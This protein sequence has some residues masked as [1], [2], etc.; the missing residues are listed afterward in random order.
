[1]TS[2]CRE[3]GSPHRVTRM[4]TIETESKSKLKCGIFKVFSPA[5]GLAEATLFSSFLLLK[6]KCL[7]YS[8]ARTLAEMLAS[9][10]CPF[11]VLGGGGAF[12]WRSKWV[13]PL[14]RVIWQ[15]FQKGGC[16]CCVPTF[17]PASAL[18]H[19][20]GSLH[21]DTGWLICSP[22]LFTTDREEWLKRLSLLKI[23]I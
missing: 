23:E 7:K 19:V 5:G 16:P 9:A 15:H 13:Q 10:D 14:G 3:G 6:L 1:M 18:T 22:R 20:G 17:L 4:I 11:P 2:A 8:F 21:A 12:R